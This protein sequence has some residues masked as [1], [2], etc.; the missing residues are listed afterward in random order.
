M[1]LLFEAASFQSLRIL[2]SIGLARMFR[3]FKLSRY[4]RGVAYLTKGALKSL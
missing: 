4:M 2:R 3:L 1:D